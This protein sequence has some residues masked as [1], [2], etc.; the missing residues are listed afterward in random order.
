MHDDE[1][2][3]VRDRCSDNA[4]GG[5]HR[6]SEDAALC[7]GERAGRARRR[8]ERG[9]HHAAVPRCE[10]QR[11]VSCAGAGTRASQRSRRPKWPT[12]LRILPATPTICKLVGK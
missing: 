7:A 6:Q 8:G 9:H 1:R 2:V 4:G 11:A 12:C 3:G 5:A 10:A